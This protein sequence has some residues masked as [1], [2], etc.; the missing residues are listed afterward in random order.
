MTIASILEHIRKNG[1]VSEGD[2]KFAV[3][4]R[5]RRDCRKS[6]FPIAYPPCPKLPLDFFGFVFAPLINEDLIH[7]YILKKS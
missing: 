7:A 3:L 6:S 1:L 4:V 2:E 5:V